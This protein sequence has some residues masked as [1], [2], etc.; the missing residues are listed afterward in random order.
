[1]PGRPGPADSGSV[2]GGGD[3]GAFDEARRLQ[4]LQALGEQPVG[5]AVDQRPV[6]AEV[7]GALGCGLQYRTRPAR[8]ISSRV[9]SKLGQPPPKPAEIWLGAQ[10]PR[11]LAVT[12]RT[13]GGWISPL[14][15]YVPPQ[16][17]P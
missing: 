15:I 4:L 2:R 13:A 12:G 5:D 7:P 6:V 14:N 10:K 8:P 9:P 11:M 1:M 17:V 3:D 16:Q